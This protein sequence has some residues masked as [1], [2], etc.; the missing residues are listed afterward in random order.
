MI[1]DLSSVLTH[2]NSIQSK[3]SQS[4]LE[5]A[6]KLIESKA[7]VAIPASVFLPKSIDKDSGIEEANLFLSDKELNFNTNSTFRLCFIKSN[8]TLNKLQDLLSLK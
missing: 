1:A 5:S 7:L 2:N 3:Q 4:Y 8:S 6:S